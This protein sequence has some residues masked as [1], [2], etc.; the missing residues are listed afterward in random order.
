MRFF[1]AFSIGVFAGFPASAAAQEYPVK[2]LRVIVPY[3]PG[4]GLDV[5]GRPVSQ[6]LTELWGQPVIIENR[7]G[8]GTT[9]GT[10]AVVKA[11]PDGYTLL[12][13]LSALTSGPGLYPHLPY[14]PVRDLAPIIWIATTSYVL[15]VHPS[16]PVKSVRELIAL[17]RAKPDQLNY[18][19]SGQ[20]GDPHLAA[21]LF[22]LMTGTKITHI[23]YNGGNPAAMAF[24]S[25]QVDL[26]FVP[27]VSGTP[28]IKTGKARG[29]AISSPQRSAVF[30]ELPTISEA[31]V[32]GY[33]AE[34]WS[35]LLAPAHTPRDIVTKLNGAVAK[36]VLAPEMS[37][38]LLARQTVPKGSSVEEFA[39][40]LK[41][42]VEKKTKLI[43]DAKIRVE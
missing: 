19:S 11:P 29:L 21:E 36:I 25:G 6:K 34:A 7:P 26:S 31:G 17:A 1:W 5:V 39:A 15:S 10:S 20:G 4:G 9:L 33:A 41:Q 28:Y 42:D 12:L 8:A 23:P 38:F 40:R 22:K 24:I 3:A 14:D 27:T 30:P 32:P 43:R 16:V 35:G 18:A 13:T 2:P 37:S